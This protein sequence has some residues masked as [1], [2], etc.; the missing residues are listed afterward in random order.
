MS[1]TLRDLASA[2]GVT[3]SGKP[4]RWPWLAPGEV[5][6]ANQGP[7]SHV[8]FP[9][10]RLHE[11]CRKGFLEEALFLLDKASDDERVAVDATDDGGRTALHFA[12]GWGRLDIIDTLLNRGA[13][14]EPR[15]AWGKA[16]VDWARQADQTEAVTKL[17]IEAVHRGTVGGRGAV[18]PLQ[19]FLEHALGKTEEE[20]KRDMDAFAKDAYDRY[21]A[22]DQREKD[23]K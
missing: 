15:D 11:A 19:T 20:V 18:A 5:D 7:A 10:E 17:R 6:R 14:L 2:P 9:P 1:L 12:S 8:L 16:P 22:M 21:G 23:R 13:L 4:T 3:M